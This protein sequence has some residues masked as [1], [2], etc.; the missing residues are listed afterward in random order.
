MV[1]RPP[2]DEESAAGDSR[3]LYLAWLA[4]IRLLRRDEGAFD[5]EFERVPNPCRRPPGCPLSPARSA[6]PCGLPAPGP[7]AVRGRAVDVNLARSDD[8]GGARR[9]TPRLR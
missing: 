6:A 5:E 7:R 9:A 8:M 2:D 4:G 3:S 1:D